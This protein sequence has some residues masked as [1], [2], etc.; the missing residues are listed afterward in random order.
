MKD[1]K[2]E[3]IMKQKILGKS[4]LAIAAAALTLTGASTVHADEVTGGNKEQREEALIE[5]TQDTDLLDSSKSVYSDI[6][7]EDFNAAVQSAVAGMS[8]GE[9]LDISF[10]KY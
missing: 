6:L 2:K 9:T 10:D 4:C 5:Q 3:E 1:I 7:D 8:T